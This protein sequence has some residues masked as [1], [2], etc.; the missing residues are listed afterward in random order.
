MVYCRDCPSARAACCEQG[1]YSRHL[2]AM[3]AVLFQEQSSP[4][5]HGAQG[6]SLTILGLANKQ[7]E[8]EST[9]LK[10]K[11]EDNAS[12]AAALWTSL[13]LWLLPLG[14]IQQILKP[15]EPSVLAD[16]WLSGTLTHNQPCTGATYPPNTAIYRRSTKEG[17]KL[18]TLQEVNKDGRSRT[19]RLQRAHG[20]HCRGRRVTGEQQCGILQLEEGIPGLFSCCRRKGLIS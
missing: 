14:H 13:W 6:M 4:L 8:K 7:Q 15:E 16:K 3:T 5:Q 20:R 11:R 17:E 18:Q 19:A 9:Y 1:N 12:I 2:A 10:K